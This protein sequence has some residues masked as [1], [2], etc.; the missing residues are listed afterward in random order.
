MSQARDVKVPWKELEKGISSQL[1]RQSQV[2]TTTCGLG[3]LWGVWQVTMAGRGP[4]ETN[5]RS[6]GLNGEWEFVLNVVGS[7]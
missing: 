7:H 5:G 6:W 1:H 3:E 2:C 4:E